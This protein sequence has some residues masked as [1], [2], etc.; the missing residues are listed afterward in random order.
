MAKMFHY[1]ENVY[2]DFFDLTV[3]KYEINKSPKCTSL[4]M[5]CSK[6]RRF[7][8]L[9]PRP[10][11]GSLRRSPRPPSRKGLLAFGN[12]SF[13]PSALAIFSTSTTYE[14]LWSK[15]FDPPPFLGQITHWC[16]LLCVHNLCAWMAAH[17]CDF[18]SLWLKPKYRILWN[19]DT[20]S[21]R[22]WLRCD[23][24]WQRRC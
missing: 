16:V 24:W 15:K 14:R 6:S 13:V 2:V 3:K 22:R 9:R 7:L 19:R 8:G 18:P 4:G 1:I 21:W 10:R 20:R 12:R 11:W 23:P 17:M 5:K